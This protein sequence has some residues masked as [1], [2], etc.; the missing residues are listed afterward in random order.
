MEMPPRAKRGGV[1]YLLR[2]CPLGLRWS[3]RP[4]IASWPAVAFPAPVSW[5]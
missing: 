2:S 3:P 1:V 5:P 4:G